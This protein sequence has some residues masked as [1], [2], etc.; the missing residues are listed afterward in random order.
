VKKEKSETPEPQKTKFKKKPEEKQSNEFIES[1]KLPVIKKLRI[2]KSVDLEVFKKKEKKMVQQSIRLEAPKIEKSSFEEERL[3]DSQRS[4]VSSHKQTPRIDSF[5]ESSKVS[6]IDKIPPNISKQLR[7]SITE[8]KPLFIKEE[9]YE[10]PQKN[11]TLE[12]EYIPLPNLKPERPQ[13]PFSL[14]DSLSQVLKA[15]LHTE[16]LIKRY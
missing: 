15:E 1:D 5:R 4:K 3:D 16:A 10:I 9:V 7:R 6:I 14:D 12:L 11:R 8:S 2:T 13:F